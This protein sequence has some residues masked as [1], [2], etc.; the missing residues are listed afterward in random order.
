MS[1]RNQ[2]LARGV[3]GLL[4]FAWMGELSRADNTNLQ[5]R[6]EDK[7]VSKQAVGPG[8]PIHVADYTVK[9]ILA[10]GSRITELYVIVAGRHRF[11]PLVDLAGMNHHLRWPGDTNAE[12]SNGISFREAEWGLPRVAEL[13]DEPVEVYSGAYSSVSLTNPPPTADMWDTVVTFRLKFK[14]PLRIIDGD[15]PVTYELIVIPSDYIQHRNAF[16]VRVAKGGVHIPRPDSN[17]RNVDS[18]G[19]DFACMN[20]PQP[21]GTPVGFVPCYPEADCDDLY[22]VKDRSQG[23]L[24]AFPEQQ[25]LVRFDPIRDG[26]GVYYWPDPGRPEGYENLWFR[27]DCIWLAHL[28]Q[29]V[30]DP[31][32]LT[33]TDRRPCMTAHFPA[34]PTL[35]VGEI[36]AGNPLW[37][38]AVPSFQNPPGVP[39]IDQAIYINDIFRD[40]YLNDE[41]GLFWGYLQRPDSPYPDQNV[42]AFYDENGNG[43]FDLYVD[44]ITAYWG[45]YESYPLAEEENDEDIFYIGPPPEIVFGGHATETGNYSDSTELDTDKGA[46]SGMRCESFVWDMRPFYNNLPG[47]VF[48]TMA[49]YPFSRPK[50]YQRP[51]PDVGPG[52]WEAVFSNWPQSE[53][54]SLEDRHAVVGIDMGGAYLAGSAPY[55]LGRV[56]ATIWDAGRDEAFDPVRMLD[57]PV[58]NPT[59]SRFSGI[60]LY[61][62]GK[63]DG[64]GENFWFDPDEDVP[65]VVTDGPDFWRDVNDMTDLYEEG[66]TVGPWEITMRTYRDAGG[67]YWEWDPNSVLDEVA[68]TAPT[69]PGHPFESWYE[70]T[71]DFFVVVRPDSGFDDSGPYTRDGFGALFGS[72][73]R[74]Y[75]GPGDVDLYFGESGGFAA[76]TRNNMLLLEDLVGFSP[77]STSMRLIDADGDNYRGNT[78]LIGAP[79]SH[80]DE[81]DVKYLEDYGDE[82]GYM[83]MPDL[84]YTGMTMPD[85]IKAGQWPFWDLLVY[86]EG[87][88]ENLRPGEAL[89]LFDTDDKVY[90]Y[91]TEP[92]GVWNGPVTYDTNNADGLWID[93]VEDGLYVPGDDR[94][95]IQG[96]MQPAVEECRGRELDAESGFA[97]YNA[98]SAVDPTFDEGEM[99]FYTHQPGDNVY[100]SK[101]RR[102][103]AV[104]DPG[105]DYFNDN[106]YFIDDFELESQLAWDEVL[107]QMPDFRYTPGVDDLFLDMDGDGIYDA[108][109]D[110][111]IVSE[112]V[113]SEPGD[114]L[115]EQGY[116][117]QDIRDFATRPVG[118]LWEP[119][120]VSPFFSLDWDGDGVS[121]EI[122][123]YETYT[124]GS[125]I[126]TTAYNGF[127]LEL[128]YYDANSNKRYDIGEDILWDHF[129]FG[130]YPFSDQ[131]AYFKWWPDEDIVPREFEP[132]PRSDWSHLLTEAAWMDPHV[133]LSWIGLELHDYATRPGILR[134]SRALPD[135]K[136][137]VSAIAMGPVSFDPPI[138]VAGINLCSS[139]DPVTQQDAPEFLQAVRVD[140]M[141]RLTLSGDP[142]AKAA[143]KPNLATDT[144][145][146]PGSGD[147]DLAPLANGVVTVS[148]DGEPYTISVSGASLFKDNKEQG[149]KGVFD[150]PADQAIPLQT[151][152]WQWDGDKGNWYVILRPSQPQEVHPDD[153]AFVWPEGSTTGGIYSDLEM[154]QY[155]GDDFFVCIIPSKDLTYENEMQVTVLDSDENPGT[156]NWGVQLTHGENAQGSG[157]N[158]AGVL[159]A[160]M[161][162]Q[163]VNLIAA[164]DTVDANSD[165]RAVFGINMM[166]DN[167]ERPDVW[168]EYLVVE[169]YDQDND[170]QFN[171][172][173]DLGPLRF[174]KTGD[175]NDI[176]FSGLALYEDTNQNGQFDAPVV[177]YSTDG[178]CNILG[179]T[180]PDEP[181]ILDYAPT[182]IGEPGEPTQVELSF[183]NPALRR[184]IPPHDDSG[185]GGDFSGPDFFVV[186]ATSDSINQDDDFRFGIVGMGPEEEP[187]YGYR[188]VG[189]VEERSDGGSYSIYT[190][191]TY[192]TMISGTLTCDPAGGGDPEAP[193]LLS[194]DTMDTCNTVQLCWT[195]VEADTF[196]NPVN[197][198]DLA[199]YNIYRATS[200]AFSLVASVPYNPTQVGTEWI[201]CM[202]DTSVENGIE[203]RYVV[204]AVDNETCPGP[205]E[206]ENSNE[207][208]ITPECPEPSCPD[209][210]A[211]AFNGNIVVSWTQSPEAD[212]LGYNVFRRAA[213]GVYNFNDPL[214][215]ATLIPRNTV[216]FA[217]RNVVDGTEYC[218]TVI[219]VDVDGFESQDCQEA[220]VEALMMPPD[221]PQL[222]GIGG[223]DGYTILNWQ[224]PQNDDLDGFNL[225]RR[226]SGGTY[227]YND[228]LNPL[229][230]N[231]SILTYTDNDVFNGEE[232]CYVIRAVDTSGTE[233]GDSNEVCLIPVGEPPDPPYLRVTE[234]TRD[235]VELSWTLEEDPEDLA[236]FR[237]YRST[238]SGLFANPL[239]N[240]TQS[241]RTYRDNAVVPGT[242]YYYVVTTTDEPGNESERSNQVQATPKLKP[243]AP[244]GLVA[245]PLDAMVLLSWGRNQESNLL[246]YEAFEVS[247]TWQQLPGGSVILSATRFLHWNAPG[248]RGLTSNTTYGYQVRAVDTGMNY[249]DLSA[250]SEAHV[251]S[252]A[253]APPIPVAS[254]GDSTIVIQWKDARAVDVVKYVLSRSDMENSGYS[255]VGMVDDTGYGLING[256]TYTYV[257]ST[258]PDDATYYYRLRAEDKDGLRGRVS[259]WTRASVDPS[260]AP[261]NP[262]RNLRATPGDGMVRLDWDPSLEADF[263]H[264]S[265]YQA[266]TELGP[267]T[268]VGTDVGMPTYEVPDLTNGVTYYFYVTA[269]DVHGNESLPSNIAAATPQLGLCFVS[270]PRNLNSTSDDEWI[271]LNWTPSSDPT[272]TSYNVYRIYPLL[273]LEFELMAT[274]PATQ[275]WYVEDWLL[276][277][278]YHSG[279]K[280]CYYISAVGSCESGAS[281]LLCGI[282]RPGGG[283]GL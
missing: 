37:M 191:R 31:D 257:D 71:P 241:V 217:D 106:V 18:N 29:N 40:L 110:R 224:P 113:G 225:Y 253:P 26:F 219:A 202:T 189:F 251:G 157:L 33:F 39:I 58:N 35:W 14:Y 103:F 144:P 104:D 69:S 114:G 238:L 44:D 256:T 15:D 230:I 34:Q 176:A 142:E 159:R 178:N 246:G 213:G 4:M 118:L 183:K 156:T 13:V 184:T 208:R 278:V 100:R 61:R 21:T 19:A 282:G 139:P 72:N 210:N 56:T 175:E 81:Y 119:S 116:S 163:L 158:D 232:Y 180:Y 271:Y 82:P 53:V 77:M 168:F 274:V 90:W 16:C 272:V 221:P 275:N 161:N 273:E 228:P 267:W 223:L 68:E 263:S 109:T 9:N 38:D 57:S 96:E 162:V 47:E 133:K 182:F 101:M 229:M 259:P 167:A 187:D 193:V 235:Y 48:D 59:F 199:G 79:C 43:R 186:F 62:D 137:D 67:G 10:G 261:P 231:E 128:G 220:C 270:P 23:L 153:A 242:T 252:R 2:G 80:P 141:P 125:T 197:P 262:P 112:P 88:E 216:Q 78:L 95:L 240:L 105:G 222:S 151:F 171:P 73:F 276:Q 255:M 166:N 146:D 99:I 65:L 209:V 190:T 93:D 247:P 32:T 277:P 245:H 84:D 83:A 127:G 70:P 164:G 145:N 124:D 126:W 97:Y 66:G 51:R 149:A 111:L 36:G 3:L 20:C 52:T 22:D 60:W 150:L 85:W 227:N 165:P 140:F 54:L 134:Q 279:N 117:E 234:V 205:Y 76:R 120:N 45:T 233:S 123:E 28:N 55:L 174:Q 254:S 12:Q 211:V 49:Y 75:I 98:D 215:G 115:R 17:D 207:L 244:E 239:V 170:D 248:G 237:L 154:G 42:L 281:N 148:M 92:F 86:P 260:V 196:G 185:P 204:R 27:N 91:D 212:V 107:I 264:Y 130:W 147:S 177:Q 179:I 6:W 198:P 8:M 94:L 108:G 30:Y 64:S 135:P 136:I 5:E 138:P 11:H 129:A 269:W 74:A 122:N 218:Y 173:T 194:A 265:V 46:N 226:D 195:A 155:A 25:E 7:T 24:N 250:L 236:G 87:T 206:S 152:Q 102:F 283:W 89:E 131:P 181:V 200:G 201:Q 121:G 169:L 249:S 172:A 1:R 143:F 243:D 132:F 214:N 50:E 258:V 280:V 41:T 203:Y 268:E 192:P 63:L 160:N 266:T 188:A